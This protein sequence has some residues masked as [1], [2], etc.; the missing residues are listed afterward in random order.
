MLRLARGEEG[1]VRQYDVYLEQ[2][3]DGE[4]ALAGEVAEPTAERQP[5]D[6]G[7]G[8]DAAGSRHAEGMGGAVHV[9]P[10]RAARDAHRAT[11]RVDAD[12]AHQGEIDDETIVADAEAR[13]V[14]P[15]ATDGNEQPVIAREVDGGDHVRGIGAANDQRGPTVVIAL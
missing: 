14:V 1:A 8:D 5:A 13:A 11:L 7:G 4:A 6:A 9:R 12:A 15:A 10:G 2:V 3:V